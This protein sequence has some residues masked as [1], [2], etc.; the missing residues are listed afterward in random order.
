[1]YISFHS[2]TLSVIYNI[3]KRL[4]K[5]HISDSFRLPNGFIKR[6]KHV[7]DLIIF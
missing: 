4:L 1:M 6:P 7:A 3:I 2:N 5:Y